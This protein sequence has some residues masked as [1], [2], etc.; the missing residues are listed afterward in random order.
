MLLVLLLVVEVLEAGFGVARVEE[1]QIIE[2]LGGAH[3]VIAEAAEGLPVNVVTLVA[4]EVLAGVDDDAHAGW[5]IADGTEL[6]LLV[7]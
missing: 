6:G 7:D 5:V 4:H 3:D 2:A 1:P